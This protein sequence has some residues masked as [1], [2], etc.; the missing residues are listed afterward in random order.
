[1]KKLIFWISQ[2]IIKRLKI[3]FNKL[4]TFIFD[5]F[6]IK[7]DS[8]HQL[9]SDLSDKKIPSF[10]QILH[11]GRFMKKKEKRVFF[12]FFVIGILSLLFL[13]YRTFVAHTSNVPVKGGEYTEGLIG[14]IEYL[15][16]VLNQNNDVDRD[17]SKLIFSGLF[18]INING[19]L[20]ND[21]VRDYSISD[22][23][24]V[25]TFNLKDDIYFHDGV[26]M[27][28]DDVEF[29]FYAIQNP[30]FNSPLY[31]TFNGVVFE[32]ISDKSF[33]L[34][35]EEPLPI[36]LKTLTFGILPAHLWQDIAPENVTL[37]EL[38]KKPIGTGPYAFYSIKKDSDGHIRQYT[39]SRF[40]NF[41]G[42]KPY[43]DK[44]SFKFYFDSEHAVEDLKSSKILSMNYISNE[45]AQKIK[46]LR[47][48]DLRQVKMPRYSALFFNPKKA[49]FLKEKKIRQAL[50]LLINKDE[51]SKHVGLEN[52][53][54]Y[55]P[56]DAIITP[57]KDEY[58]VE[59][60]K[61]LL[62]ESG[63][64]NDEGILKKAGD[65][66]TIKITTLDNA[67]YQKIAYFI[68]DEWA[69]VGISVEIETI[70]RQKI[71]KDII[72][73][74][75]YQILLYSQVLSY[76]MD[77]YVFWHSSQIGSS[78][79]NLSIFSDNDVDTILEEARKIESDDEKKLKYE[80]FQK[81]IKDNVYAIFL[82]N[83]PYNYP[84]NKKVKGFSSELIYSPSDRFWN[85]EDWY[86]KYKLVF[87]SK[88]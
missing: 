43:I 49:D 23:K 84:L 40:E 25:Y 76:D 79:F 42:E 75:N 59:R 21:L 62:D 87:S 28:T 5:I 3:F 33:N 53:I 46:G 68:K 41:Y 39:L 19:E 70:D 15:N 13:F 20:E 26:S 83:T 8:D 55:G 12:T 29:T 52:Y 51:M 57:S 1:V 7:Q 45:T 65:Q 82:F 73:P 78:G 80:N 22:D 34:I 85:I 27:N 66:M 81:I 61:T 88:K 2:N 17:I 86:I 44:I 30:N 14:S 56:L 10:R 32:K 64:K 77:P 48:F 72:Q 4:K 58:D 47:H 60:A 36:F 71:M 50:S 54:A 67:D 74:R 6:K 9:I 24:T 35:L 31:K 18:K 11:V 38:N 63:W 69:K 37:S 16:P